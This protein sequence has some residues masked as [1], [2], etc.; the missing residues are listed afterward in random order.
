MDLRRP[1]GGGGKPFARRCRRGRLLALFTVAACV[2]GQLP[3]GENTVYVAPK[4]D[5]TWSG[6][7]AAPN[8]DGTDGPVATL[9]RAIAA[10]RARRRGTAGGYEVCVREGMYLL[11]EPLQLSGKDSGNAEHPTVLRAYEGEKPVFSG[12]RRVVGW[13]PHQ[14]AVLRTVL[15]ANGLSDVQVKQL[16]AGGRRLHL[17]RHPNHDP[18]HPLTGGWAYVDK[19][20]PP[21][22]VLEEFGAKRVLRMQ[23]QDVR[24]WAHPEHGN[25][26]IFPGHE[27]WNNIVPVSTVDVSNGLIV[28]KRNCSYEIGP[29]DRYYVRGMAEELDAPGEWW[30]DAAEGALYLW[31]GESLNPESVFVP[32]MRTIIEITSARCIQVRGITL[33]HCD[34]SAVVVQDS[35]NCLVAECAIRAVGDYH[36]SGVSVTGGMENGVVGCDIRDTGHSGISLAGGDQKTR[37]PAGNYAENNHITRTGFY[38]K[39]GSGISVRGVGNRVSRNTIHHVPRWAIGFG[40]NDHLIELNDLHHVSLETTDTG[41]IY[42]GSLN[43]LSGHGVAIRHNFIH[44]VIGRGR[45]NGEWRAP[46]FGWGIYLDWTAMGVTVTGNV[47]TRAPR[48]GIMVHD[49]R[50]NTIENNIVYDCGTGEHDPGSQ[51]E[52]SGWDVNHYFWK[53]GLTFGWVRQFESVAEESAWHGDG[54][55]LRDPRKSALPDGRTMHSNTVRGNIFCARAPKSAVFRFRGVSFEHNP[56]DRN[57]VWHG[58]AAIKTGLLRAKDET[59]PNLIPTSGFEDNRKGETVPTGWRARLPWDGCRVSRVAEGAH[60]GAGALLLRGAASATLEGRPAWERH[61]AVQTDY[62]RTVVPGRHYRVSVWVRAGLPGARVRLEALSYKGGAYDVR[63]SR[64]EA[65]IGKEW[66]EMTGVFKLP[67]PGDGQYRSGIENTFYVR[68]VLCQDEGGLWLDDVALREVEV[69]DEWDAWQAEGMDRGSVVADPL[70]M[71]PD[72]DDFRLRPESPAWDLGFRAIPFG[73][74]GCDQAVAP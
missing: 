19:A 30:A 15:A 8:A 58:G 70:F 1:M 2:S 9:H 31:P 16:F 51:I 14:G 66:Q 68:V 62:I 43:W 63:L 3:G 39:Q 34:G 12:A 60:T 13:E 17:A 35:R 41:A 24:Q 59:G 38:Y 29:Q 54:S 25:V 22:D 10:A 53:K 47:I 36:G 61:V 33:Q 44:D 67:R 21:P 71:D 23:D 56:S 69:M 18:T 32:V 11:P 45:R 55:T 20:A 46:F 50:F 6:L 49:G 4:G 64:P 52:F 73:R 72:S 7:L 65:A 5:D 57:V 28:L 42:G 37:T 26:F 27:W 74:I 40:G 48:A